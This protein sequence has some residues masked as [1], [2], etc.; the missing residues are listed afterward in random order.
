MRTVKVRQNVIFPDIQQIRDEA[1]KKFGDDLGN[2]LVKIFKDIY[3]D[4]NALQEI[5]VVTTLPT[6]QAA[7]R[8]HVFVKDNGAGVADTVHVCIKNAAGGYEWKQFT[9]V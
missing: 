1:A 6:A 4:I 3:D 8:G 5:E 7:L 2:L 9:L